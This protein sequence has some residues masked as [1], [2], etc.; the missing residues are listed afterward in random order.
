MHFMV[1]PEEFKGPAA[2]F[3][4]FGGNSKGTGVPGAQFEA[5]G[6][7]SSGICQSRTQIWGTLG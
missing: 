2:E 4:A 1:I 6:V 3:R 7:N 5:F